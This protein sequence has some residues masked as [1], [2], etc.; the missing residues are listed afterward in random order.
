MRRL[1]GRAARRTSRSRPS[2]ASAGSPCTIRTSRSALID[3]D[4][5]VVELE[6]EAFERP[7]WAR[8]EFLGNIVTDVIDA[9]RVERV[10]AAV[11][12]RVRRP[13]GHARDWR[14]S[15]NGT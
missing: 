2:A 14:G 10:V 7:G 6:G 3:R 5:R 4:L 13:A 15:R 9:E 11:R 1:A 12:G 8:D